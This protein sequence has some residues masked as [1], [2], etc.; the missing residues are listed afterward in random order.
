MLSSMNIIVSDVGYHCYVYD[1][2][3]SGANHFE[4]CFLQMLHNNTSHYDLSCFTRTDEDASESLSTIV[5]LLDG[6]QDQSS[7]VRAT[8][9]YQ[10]MAGS[11]LRKVHCVQSIMITY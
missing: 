10:S 11:N 7:H 6:F 3:L 4:V 9:T 1:R 5:T 8:T 2:S